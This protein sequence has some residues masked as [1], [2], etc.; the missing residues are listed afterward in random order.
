[1]SNKELLKLNLGC[2]LNAPSGWVNIDAPFTARLSKW[3]RLYKVACKIGRIKLVEWPENIKIYDIRKGL[4]FS[5]GS[6]RLI[7]ASHALDH[8]TYK[9]ARFVIG[10]YHRCLCEGR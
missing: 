5:D 4:P 10:G 1:M 3:K 6:V 2:G 8:I 7:F 9:D